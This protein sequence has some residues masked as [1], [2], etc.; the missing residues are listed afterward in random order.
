LA[1]E[2]VLLSVSQILG[3]LHHQY[4]RMSFSVGTMGSPPRDDN[5]DQ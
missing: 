4:H 5:R 1:D 2:E 3:G